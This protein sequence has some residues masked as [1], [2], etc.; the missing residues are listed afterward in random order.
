MNNIIKKQ[1]DQIT[2]TNIEFNDDTTEIFI[3]KTTSYNL[4]SLKKDSVYLI[5]LNDSLLNPS[6]SSTLASNWNAGRVPKYKHYN[7]EVNSVMN[8]MVQ[9]TAVPIINGEAIYK[10]QF[11]GWL[12]FDQIKV[13]KQL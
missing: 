4:K 12:P 11:Y 9:V 1:L 5:E 3:P 6:S 2:A 13:I 8:K 10:E 7:A